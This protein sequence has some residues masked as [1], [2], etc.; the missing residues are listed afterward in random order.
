[1]KS[2]T[3][4]GKQLRDG[5]KFCS[6]CGATVTPT[7][8]VHCLKCNAELHGNAKFCAECGTPV[9]EKGIGGIDGRQPATETKQPVER[10]DFITW[11]SKWSGAVYNFRVNKDQNSF[12][13]VVREFV[14]MTNASSEGHEFQNYIFLGL[15]QLATESNL[16]QAANAAG[17]VL[18]DR[19]QN[20]LKDPKT[21]LDDPK[22]IAA[23]I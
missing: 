19:F 2:C 12:T 16:E 13:Q 10:R 22:T 9:G 21:I 18:P 5:S 14:S 8:A 20:A 6:S 17:K 11:I 4:C 3:K 23:L 7:K 1:M 15:L